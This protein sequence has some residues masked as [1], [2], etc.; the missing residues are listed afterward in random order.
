MVVNPEKFQAI[1]FKKRKHHSNEAIKFDNKTSETVSSVRI[2]GV[3]VNGEINF[4]LHVSNICKSA[5][6]L[7]ALIRLNN[8]SCFERKI[9]LIN[10]YFKS[11]FNYCLLVWMLSNATSHIH[12]VHLFKTRNFTPFLKY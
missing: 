7:T 9:V 1:I 11:N 6:Q 2:L 3:Q 12:R 8:F 4:S 10:G 5:N